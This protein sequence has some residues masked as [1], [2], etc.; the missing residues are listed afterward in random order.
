ML[1]IGLKLEKEIIVS[2]ST[3][4]KHM[5]SGDLDVYATPCMIALMEG[6]ANDS[7]KEYLDDGQGSVGTLINVKHLSASPLNIKV[8][9]TSE[10]VE[11]DGKRLVFNVQAFDEN[12]LIGEGRHERYVISN[13][14]FMQRVSEKTKKI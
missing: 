8:R 6:T 3:T 14:K 9:A 4:A 5:G 1:K 2:E 10:L 11:I 13:D 7:I 12:G